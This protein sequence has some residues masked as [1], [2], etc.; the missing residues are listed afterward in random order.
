MPGL[1]PGMTLARFGKRLLNHSAKSSTMPS[2]A[3]FFG[4]A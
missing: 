1:A 3:P 2:N 4:G